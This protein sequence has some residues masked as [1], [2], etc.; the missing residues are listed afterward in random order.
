M[1]E[2]LKTLADNEN[3]LNAL[4]AHL[5]SKF[6]MNFADLNGKDNAELTDIIRARLTGR[7]LVEEAIGEVS[8]LRVPVK[9]RGE[10]NRA[11]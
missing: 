6:E 2:I 10:L 8:R 7:H 3:L 9:E 11:R 1:P 5:L 4:K